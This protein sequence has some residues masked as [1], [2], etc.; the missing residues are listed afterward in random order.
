M[1]QGVCVCKLV[2]VYVPGK[3]CDM[4]VLPWPVP[5]PECVCVVSSRPPHAASAALPSVPPALS[6]GPQKRGMREGE[7]R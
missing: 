5:A 1:N 4:C 6:T 3:L 2:Y 7:G